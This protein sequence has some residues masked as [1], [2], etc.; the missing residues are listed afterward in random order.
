MGIWKGLYEFPFLEFSDNLSDSKVIKS[1]VWEKLFGEHNPEIQL[2]SFN[3][4]HKL[5]HQKIYA[6]FWKIKVKNFSIKDFDKVDLK[7]LKKYPVSRLME[8]YLKTINTD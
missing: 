7:V 1:D 2:D 6:K 8:K 3:Y 4:I 5:T